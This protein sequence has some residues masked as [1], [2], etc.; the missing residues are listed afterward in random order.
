MS[1]SMVLYISAV[2]L[3]AIVFVSYVA[4]KRA[5]NLLKLTADEIVEKIQKQQKIK[6]NNLKK[7]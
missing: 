6:F 2:V 5:K 7:S 4:V 3:T 1:I